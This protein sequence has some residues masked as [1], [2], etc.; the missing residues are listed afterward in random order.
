MKTLTLSVFFFFLCSCT[1]FKVRHEEGSLPDIEIE[2]CSKFCND[3][4]GAKI[5]Q[6]EFEFRCKRKV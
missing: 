1:V 2:T 5:K 6:S 3:Q 4:C